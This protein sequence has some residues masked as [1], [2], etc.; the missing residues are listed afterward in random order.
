MVTPPALFDFA[1]MGANLAEGIFQY[2][3]STPMLESEQELV[4]SNVQDD[5]EV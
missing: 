1:C 2:L 5:E 4:V 3:H